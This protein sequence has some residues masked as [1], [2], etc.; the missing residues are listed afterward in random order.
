M[1]H[2]PPIL[3]DIRP[4]PQLSTHMTYV[5]PS[6][7][8]LAPSFPSTAWHLP[9]TMLATAASVQTMM[10]LPALRPRVCVRG[11]RVIGGKGGG[12]HTLTVMMVLPA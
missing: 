6:P 2:P 1:P 3:N 8:P 10:V 12:V 4:T 5:L 11:E 7:P 9:D